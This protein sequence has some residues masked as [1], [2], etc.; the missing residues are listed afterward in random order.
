[1]IFFTIVFYILIQKNI[2]FVK[3]VAIKLTFYYV[4]LNMI[5]SLG[6]RKKYIY[7]IFFFLFLFIF[8]LFKK[9][10]N[11]I[12][13]DTKLILKKYSPGMN[14]FLDRDYINKKNNKFLINKYI[15][16]IPRHYKKNIEI[17]HNGNIILYRA[18][19][20]K[21]NNTY[22]DWKI[23]DKKLSITGISCIHVNVIKKEFNS[24]LHIIK[25]GGPVSSD[26]IFLEKLE[27][28]DIIINN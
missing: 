16:Q 18:L 23:L 28:Q 10:D 8:Y 3:S 2:F 6:H 13:N 21:N 11:L 15:L 20:N 19:C 22:E 17:Q 1:M 12:K 5:V 26:P 4:I 27:D 25:S 7:V 14:I 9:E 24:G